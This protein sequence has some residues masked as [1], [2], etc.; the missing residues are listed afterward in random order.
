MIFKKLNL[1][2]RVILI[3][4]SIAMLMG[5]STHISWAIQNGFLSEHYNA[6]LATQ[7]FWDSLTFLDPLAALLLILRPKFGVLLTLIVITVDVV[8]NNL[9]YSNELYLSSISLNDWILK[10]WMILGQILFAIFVYLTFRKNW[11]SI[12]EASPQK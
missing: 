3:I 6:P 5:A 2:T 12:L 4:Q 11:K 7:L 10:Y 8:H 9:F 1:R